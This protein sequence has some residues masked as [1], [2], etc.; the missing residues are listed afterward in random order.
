MD[1]RLIRSL[2]STGYLQ[3]VHTSRIRVHQHCH[4]ALGFASESGKNQGI[5]GRYA[6]YYSY[7]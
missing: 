3:V 2:N 7:Y 1:N 6:G 5:P 4:K